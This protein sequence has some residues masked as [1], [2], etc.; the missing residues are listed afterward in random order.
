MRSAT[1]RRRD[2]GLRRLRTV[3]RVL[4]AAA[5]G[6]TGLLSDVAANAFPGHKRRAATTSASATGSD[7]AVTTTTSHR[8]RRHH[9][10]RAHHALSRP[11]QAPAATTS[12]A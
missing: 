12:A 9:H 1:A 7:P 11:A 5:V 8:Q 2:T 10:R 4:I 3:N 6:L